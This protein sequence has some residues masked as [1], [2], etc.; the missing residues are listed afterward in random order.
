VRYGPGVPAV[1]PG[2]QPGLTSQWMWRTGQPPT[3]R[4]NSHRLRRLVGSALTVVLL[5]ASAVVL[6]LRFHH[7]PFQVTGVTISQ[8]AHAGCGMSVTGLIATNGSAGTVTYQWLV[9]PAGQPPQ[10]VNQSVPAGQP[11]VYVNVAIQGSGQGSASRTV[12]LQV[13]GPDPRS[14]SAAVVIQ[15]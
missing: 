14:A 1:P 3:P 10:P 2:G 9:L 13:L 12:T 7:M 8:Q 5:A 4:R 6:Y 11:A 15:C